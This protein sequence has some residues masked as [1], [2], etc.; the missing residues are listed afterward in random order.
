[1][2]KSVSTGATPHLKCI[3]TISGGRCVFALSVSHRMLRALLGLV[4]G[5]GVLSG[6]VMAATPS[7]VEQPHKSWAQVLMQTEQRISQ[8]L[9]TEADR[10]RFAAEQARANGILA[11]APVVDGLYRSDRLMS[12]FGSTE[13]QLGVRL[14]LRRFGQSDAWR[15]LAEQSALNARTRTEANRLVLLGELRQ[16]AWGWRQAE[17]ELATAK[18][19]NRIMQRDLAAVTKQFKHGE[20]AE[21]DRMSVESR[22]LAVQEAVTA[23]QMQ[24]DTIQ[25]RW[26]QLTGTSQLPSDLGQVTSTEQAL[27]NNPELN[28]PDGLLAQQPLL[29]QMASEVGMSTARIDAERAAG[30]GAPEIGLGVKRDRGD[31]GIPYD[32][33]LQLTLSIPFGGQKYRDPA[34]AE[35]AQQRATAQVALIKN[36]Q[37]ILGEVMALRQRIAAWPSRLAQLDRRAALSE[38]TLTL[39]Q[40]A[41]RLGELDWTSLLVF[42]RDTAEARLQARL[43]HIAY[44]ADQS[45]LKQTLGLMPAAE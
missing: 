23:A 6:T 16:M 17:V 14:P 11:G 30:A 31:R 9:V 25:T 13:M 24:L 34:L 45:S 33:S 26:Q 8:N 37:Q 27:L 39:K 22:A 5:A 29:R 36:T 21:V 38:K 19:R 15:S 12:D 40:K 20:A 43:A 4:L 1:M 32:N 7:P 3:T 18:E 35:M 10:T 2:K 28:T 44:R 41:L 42:E